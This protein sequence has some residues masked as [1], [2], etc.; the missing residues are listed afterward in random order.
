MWVKCLLVKVVINSII[1]AHNNDVFV[2][3]HPSSEHSYD[4]ICNTQ[5]KTY[6]L[7]DGFVNP[8]FKPQN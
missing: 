8:R 2:G 6:Q 3:G 7:V 1:N 5:H 4:K